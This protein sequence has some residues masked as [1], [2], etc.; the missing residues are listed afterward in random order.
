M[1]LLA[2]MRAYAHTKPKRLGVLGAGTDGQIGDVPG[3][4][5]DNEMTERST[6]RSPTGVGVGASDPAF[7]TPRSS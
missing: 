6:G 1:V 3:L 2:L 5:L 4:E 7:S